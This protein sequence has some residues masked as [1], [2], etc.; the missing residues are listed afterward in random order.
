M[1]QEITEASRRPYCRFPIRY[2]DCFAA[3][4]PHLN[5]MFALVRAYRLRALVELSAGQS[6]A[7]L[8]D[9]QTI[10][11]VADKLN[12]EPILISFLV[13]VAMLD[14]ATQPIWEGLAAHRWNESQL[15]ALQ[16]QWAANPHRGRWGQR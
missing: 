6:D 11:R 15:A 12:G 10:L 9:V 7:A 13:R 8:A 4:L 1:L 14:I 2:E 16:A 5:Y 3:L